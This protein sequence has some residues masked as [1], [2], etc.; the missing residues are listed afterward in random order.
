MIT[1]K[2]IIDCMS[3]DNAPH[4][5][6]KGAVEG[7][8]KNNVDLLLV[9]SETVIRSELSGLDTE[10]VDIEIYNV[11][12][13][14]ITMED[15]PGVVIKS[16]KDSSMAQALKL[17]SEG[18]GH[19]VIS[20]GNT[21]ALFM[22]ASLIVKRIKGIRRAA[23]GALVP[24]GGHATMVADAGANTDAMPETMRESALMGKL[25][26]EKVMGIENPR[27]GLINNGA[28]EKKGTELYRE[29]YKL[30]KELDINFVGNVEGRDFPNDACDVLVTDGFTGNIIVKLTE[31]FGVFMKSQL[32]KIFYANVGTKIAAGM[33]SGEL[34]RIKREMDYSEFGGAPFLGISR[35]VIK[36]HGSAN[37]KSIS[38]CVGQA[39]NYIKSGI[40]SEYALMAKDPSAY[41]KPV[42][43]EDVADE[44]ADNAA[45]AAEDSENKE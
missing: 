7:G 16:K 6:I 40:I 22:G 36:A 42:P 28:E 39:K 30:L 37:A 43:F 4:E 34:K 25:F 38:C 11:D 31:G 1:V 8:R 33:V 12:G 17:L 45:N 3:G 5:I 21:G 41:L 29:T 19:A 2:I 20:A 9:G 44:N 18:V 35:P 27:V 14:P 24:L 32:K 23:L 13:E 26:M 15:D 10:D